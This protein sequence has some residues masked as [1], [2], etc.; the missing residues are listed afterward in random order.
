MN[1]IDRLGQA[2]IVRTAD[3]QAAIFPRGSGSPGYLL[4]TPQALDRAR[5]I[6]GAMSL[7]PLGS[8]PVFLTLNVLL[9]DSQSLWKSLIYLLLV[10]PLGLLLSPHLIGR[11]LT[12]VQP[13]DFTCAQVLR[14]NLIGAAY[15]PLVIG[16]AAFV[17]ANIW[18]Y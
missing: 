6:Q 9:A 1:V 5:R 4:D 3:G 12:V 15:W 16:Y 18:A 7:L 2:W 14:A 17:L 11:G 10:T 13:D 8:L